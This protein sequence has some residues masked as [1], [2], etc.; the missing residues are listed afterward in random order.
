MS[1]SKTREL[2]NNT[3]SRFILVI[4]IIL[5]LSLAIT[6][7][8]LFPPSSTTGTSA[9]QGTLNISDSGPIT[10]D[11]ATA[12]EVGSASY[13][14]QIFSGLVQL[15]DSLQIVPD[16]AQS[17]D[18]SEDRKTYTFHLRQD[19][20][21]HD[22]KAVTANDF[23]YSWERA[24]NPATQS[25]TARTY[26]NDIAGASEMISGQT[27]QLSGVKVLD[28]YTL[29]VSITT[30]IT[31]F[32]EKMA[33][34]TAFVVDQADVQSGSS[35]WQ[36]P[37]GTGPFKL[38]QWVIDQTLI[39]ERNDNYYGEKA[40]LNQVVFKLYSGNSMQLYQT[41]DVDITGIGADY[42]GLATDPTNPVNKQLAIFPSLSVSYLGFNT[43]KPPFDDV[44]IRQAF[45]Y[46]VDKNRVLTLTASNIVPVANGILPPD[47]PGYNTALQGLVFDVQKALQLIAESKYG[48][49][50]NLPPIVLTTGGWGNNISGLTGGVIAEWQR[51]LG[52]QV[53]V[54]QLEPEYYSYVLNQEKDELFDFGW[55]ADYPDP[56]DFLELLFY[57][58]NQNNIGGYSN[59]QLDALLTQAAIESDPASRIKMYQDTE[60]IIVQ[61]AAVLPLY[62]GRNYMLIQ[63]YVQGYELSP[64]GYAWLN[65]VSVQK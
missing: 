7:C 9:G 28:N 59:P 8:S 34:P 33:Y 31:F 32:L 23:K 26:L 47:M 22:G 45:S 36:H 15:D 27:T 40:K 56:Q 21:F 30:P 54:R 42:L 18:K 38:H 6:S 13:I 65:K 51:N 25:L 16:I 52:V 62:F 29:E 53:T 50:S 60:Q 19:V 14:M 61:D 57:T 58:G 49:I 1:I 39:L 12:A 11:P 20:K 3:T 2:F 64:L 46:A 48:D 63:S 55:I 24:L 44:K 5:S 4:L 17:W 10:L 37:N 35:W 41:G 43:T